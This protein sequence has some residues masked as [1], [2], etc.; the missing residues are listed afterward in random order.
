MKAQAA[1]GVASAAAPVVAPPLAGSW[2]MARR[3]S[4]MVASAMWCVSAATAV[5]AATAYVSDEL[6]LGV[7]TEQN[8]QGP[9]IATLHSGAMVDTLAVSGDF[10]QVRLSDGNVGWVKSTYLITHEPATARLKELEEELQSNHATTPELAA[11]AG[12]SEMERL[13]RALAAK[14][15]ELDAARAAAAPAPAGTAHPT[16]TATNAATAA[17]AAPAAATATAAGM[18]APAAAVAPRV[19]PP[20]DDAPHAAGPSSM[21]R[22]VPLLTAVVSLAAGFWMGYATLARRIRQKFGGIKVY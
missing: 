7:Y 17:P 21:R 3:I 13:K 14:Q 1:G 16:T 2:T 22:F 9:R 19:E 10:T 15:S 6:V 20:V 8:G 12:R 18:D 5:H 11:A 4:V